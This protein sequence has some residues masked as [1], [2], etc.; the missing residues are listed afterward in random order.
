MP[1]EEA[2]ALLGLAWLAPAGSALREGCRREADAILARIEALVRE[3]REEG[4]RWAT[5]SSS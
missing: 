4:D 5:P 3:E 2:Q 1:L